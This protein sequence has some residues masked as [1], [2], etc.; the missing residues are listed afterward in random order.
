MNAPRN[1]FRCTCSAEFPAEDLLIEHYREV[2]PTDALGLW[3]QMG[4][5]GDPF[6][7]LAFKTLTDQ[8]TAEKVKSRQLEEQ[9]K[10]MS[11][12]HEKLMFRH[13]QF[14]RASQIITETLTNVTEA[15]QKVD[16]HKD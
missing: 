3:G 9:I 1:K 5:V 11:K 15:I 14:A 16:S 6:C 10:I 4:D 12:A 7:N 2:H 8:I 13:N